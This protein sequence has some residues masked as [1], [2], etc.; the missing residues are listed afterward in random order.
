MSR[1]LEVQVAADTAVVKFLTA[2]V[3]ESNAQVI[4]QE[5]EAL[6]DKPHLHLDL[7]GVQYL[8]SVGLARLVALY[9]KVKAAGGQLRLVNVGGLVSEVFQ[10]TKLDSL[11]DIRRKAAG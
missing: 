3:D 1:L 2:K 9:R 4:G 6:A 11:M 5:L 10:V 8:S 7:D